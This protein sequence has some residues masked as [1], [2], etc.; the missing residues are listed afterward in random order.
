[1]SL[2]FSEDSVS[3]VFFP[4]GD[5]APD[6]PLGLVLFQYRLSLKVEGPVKGGQPFAQVLVDGGLGNA[7]FCGR[8]ADGGPILYDVL[9]ELNSPLLH[10][11]FHAQHTPHG[12]V[13]E[14]YMSESGEI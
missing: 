1:M 4:G 7:E 11:P 9:G 10:I 5:A 14:M 6:V 3:L 2:L 8:S 13:W 12:S